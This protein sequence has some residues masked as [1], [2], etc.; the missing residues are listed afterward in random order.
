MGIT[1]APINGIM[2]NHYMRL[3][4]LSAAVLATVGFATIA[5]AQPRGITVYTDVEFNGTS[6][7]FTQAMPDLRSV[8][9][10]DTISSIQI[11]SGE[12]W[13]VCEDINYEGRCQEISRRVGDLRNI[14]LNDQIS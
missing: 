4:R 7:R 10:N 12:V 2:K 8:G 5:S 11:P 1:V 3:T 13:E 14:E 6:Q 9:L